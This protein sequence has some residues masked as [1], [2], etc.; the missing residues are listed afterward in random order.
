MFVSRITLAT[1]ARCLGLMLCMLPDRGTAQTPQD[2]RSITREWVSVERAISREANEA[3]RM[4][5]L[6]S[7]RIAVLEAEINQLRAE[8]AGSADRATRAERERAALAQRET[9]TAAQH[10]QLR[11]FLLSAETRV[12]NMR[13]RLPRTFSENLAHLYQRLPEEAD[14]TH[15]GIAERLQTVIG[16]LTHIQAF[17]DSIS[18]TVE[19]KAINH[20]PAGEVTTLYLGLGQAYY[21]GA[22][23]A[24]YGYPGAQGWTWTSQP[25]LKASIAR[26]IATA[27]GRAAEPAFIELPVTLS[28][29]PAP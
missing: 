8:G 4:R 6:T 19:V 1:N 29:G 24:G 13:A 22:S 21:L 27:E 9:D 10:A 18:V 5:I 20:H 2:A 16:I 12:K 26:A 3:E 14:S 11:A 7:D 15:R 25:G 28:P 23:D 17:N